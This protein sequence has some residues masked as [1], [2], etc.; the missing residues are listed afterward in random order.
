MTEAHDLWVEFHDDGRI[1]VSFEAQE[2]TNRG[3]RKRRAIRILR[4]YMRGWHCRACGEEMPAE[5]RADAVFCREACRKAAARR[6]AR[7]RRG[8]PFDFSAPGEWLGR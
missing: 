5:R 1:T 7:W 3:S 2:Y 6:R 8:E 4:N